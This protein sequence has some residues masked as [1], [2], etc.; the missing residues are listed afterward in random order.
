MKLLDAGEVLPDDLVLR[1]VSPKLSSVDCQKR[2]WVLEGIGAAGGIDELENAVAMAA[3]VRGTEKQ[4]SDSLVPRKSRV[5]SAE[6]NILA[7]KKIHNRAAIVASVQRYTMRG[8]CCGDQN[9]MHS[10]TVCLLHA[11]LLILIVLL[12]TCFPVSSSLGGYDVPGTWFL[13]AGSC[14]GG[15]L[16]PLK[17]Y[18]TP[19]SEA[20][21]LKNQTCVL[22]FQRYVVHF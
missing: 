6:K 1:L 8:P 3:E 12:S 16:P 7:T 4:N 21:S 13:L 17:M 14:A 15:Q 5:V 2:G 11:M 9:P 22:V 19:V 10:P 18:G 20:K